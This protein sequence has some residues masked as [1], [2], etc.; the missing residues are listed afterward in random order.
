MYTSLICT[1]VALA[2]LILSGKTLRRAWH[3]LLARNGLCFITKEVG[4]LLD[5]SSSEACIVDPQEFAVLKK[6]GLPEDWFS[7]DKDGRYHTTQT[8]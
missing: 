6:L 5:G 2:C 7:V 8:V 4:S 1:P 3:P